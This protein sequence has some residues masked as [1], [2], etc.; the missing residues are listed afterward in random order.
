MGEYLTRK[1]WPKIIKTKY[2]NEQIKFFS[3]N[4]DDIKKKFI[5]SM[6][7]YYEYIGA[8]RIALGTEGINP[9]ILLL[10]NFQ[11]ARREIDIV[12]ARALLEK[13]QNQSVKKNIENKFAKDDDLGKV[14]ESI[15][16]LTVQASEN[17]CAD[18]I[19]RLTPIVTKLAM[20][21]LEK[22]SPI[23]VDKF[24]KPSINKKKIETGK[25]FY[26]TEQMEEHYDLTERPLDELKKKDYQPYCTNRY[27]FALL[28]QLKQQGRISDK[29]FSIISNVEKFEKKF[30][31]T[32]AHDIKRMDNDI[33]KKETN[34]TISDIL[35]QI[36][37]LFSFVD[38]EGVYK[39]KWDSYEIVNNEI[40]KLL[41]L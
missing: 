12:E 5:L 21:L 36:K 22:S 11:I 40:I 19:L 14:F 18:F 33:A 8:K 7:P 28:E 2:F 6:L 13:V 30:R 24:L 3:K 27:L 26:N 32:L 37:G 20:L 34:N 15:L 16:Y 23:T 29:E 10:L 31:N 41:G 25:V 1:F 35:G 9:D 4:E 39:N 17:E 38:S